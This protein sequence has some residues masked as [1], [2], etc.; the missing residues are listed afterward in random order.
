MKKILKKIIVFS[1]LA[2]IAMPQLAQADFYFNPHYII[3]DEEIS[4]YQCLSLG[5]IQ[6]FLESQGSALASRYFL[7][8][9]GVNKRAS[10]IIWQ[11]ALE[12]KIS[13]KLLLA[14]L[15]KEQSLIGDPS[16][17]QNQLDKAMGY[18]CPDSGGCNPKAAGFGK[19]VDGA[20]WQFRQYLD[21][22]FNWT[23]QAG[24]L[25]DID[26]YLITPVNQ[27]TAALYNYTPHYSGNRHFWQIW[28]D[29]WGRDF[30]DGSLLKADGSPA[31]WLLQYGTKRLITSYGI[32]LSRFD[33]KKILIVSKTDLEKYE[34]GP[35]MKFYNYSLLGLPDGS[36]YLLVDDVL[37]HIATPEV[38]KTIGFNWEEVMPAD[39][40]D[41]AG[42]SYGSEI[43]VSSVY[44]TGAL[45]QN[46]KT[47]GVY[48][49][50]NG[51]KMPIIAK[52]I[53][54][55][56]FKQKVLTPVSQE[57]LDKYQTGDP[58]KFRDGELIRSATDSRVYVI[59]G[60]YRR[61]VKSEK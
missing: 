59:S 18:R 1:A 20:A 42:Y 8:Y 50:E 24:Q 28:Q 3:S 17:S 43:T 38:F 52:E 51:I 53:L 10:E 12:S 35:S 37:H 11:A 47:G 25:F 2:A 61:W 6:Q 33:P 40:K 32:L 23:F 58:V 60:G 56:N 22:P 5:G 46:K 36:I 34:T 39:V 26:G 14:T 27:A 45:L 41:L 15:Q 30:P 7:D 4:D 57:E 31:V 29:Y 49:I 54:A 16:P 48:Y 21:N 44:P 19:Q 55:A 13:P 9:Q